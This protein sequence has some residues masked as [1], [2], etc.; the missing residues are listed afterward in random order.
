MGRDQLVA[1]IDRVR[2]D[3]LKWDNNF[4]LNCDRSGTATAPPTATGAVQAL[5]G[6]STS[7]ASA[8][9]I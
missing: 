5:Y 2:P 6:F 4:W 9:R 1:L 3:Y 7:C 8:T